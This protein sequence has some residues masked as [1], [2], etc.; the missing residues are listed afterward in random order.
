MNRWRFLKGIATTMATLML[1]K[2]KAMAEDKITTDSDRGATK[3]AAEVLADPDCHI[4]W[5][6]GENSGICHLDIPSAADE[7]TPLEDFY[8]GRMPRK[9]WALY[10]AWWRPDAPPV[11]QRDMEEISVAD[12]LTPLGHLWPDMLDHTMSTPGGTITYWFHPREEERLPDA[13]CASS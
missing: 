1:S 2:G 5:E 10:T 11:F 8:I 6:V 7:T 12:F 4:L 13:P 9:H 3:S